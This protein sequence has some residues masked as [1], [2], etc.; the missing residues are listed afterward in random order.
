MP[1]IVI[2][3]LVGCEL[4]FAA[5]YGVREHVSR[6]RHRRARDQTGPLKGPVDHPAFVKSRLFLSALTDT[7]ST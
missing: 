1:D 6:Q 2:A 7:R 3:I 4:G 5:G